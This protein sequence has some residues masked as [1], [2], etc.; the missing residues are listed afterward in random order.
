MTIFTLD[1]QIGHVQSVPNAIFCFT[2]VEHFWPLA[3]ASSFHSLQYLTLQLHASLTQ[4]FKFTCGATKLTKWQV[5]M[6]RWAPETFLPNT[7]IKSTS[8]YCQWKKKW[9]E[10]NYQA[11]MQ[12]SAVWSAEATV[13]CLWVH[14]NSH[15]SCPQ[16]IHSLHCTVRSPSATHHEQLMVFQ[17]GYEQGVLYFSCMLC[18]KSTSQSLWQWA[19]SRPCKIFLLSGCSEVS[20]WLLAS[21]AFLL[22]DALFW[23]KCIL[24]RGM[25]LFFFFF[26]L[27]LS[28]SLELVIYDLNSLL[29]YC[30]VC[31]FLVNLLDFL[32][33]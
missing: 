20:M 22:H 23:W 9:K 4:V 1:E 25:F 15:K 26:V 29:G 33:S 31:F 24:S 19:Y 21:L 18:F 11:S 17:G 14:R 32:H 30:S 27:S 5:M 3:L 28:V 16:C 10:L 8:V 2:L 12:A 13:V 6:R 7:I